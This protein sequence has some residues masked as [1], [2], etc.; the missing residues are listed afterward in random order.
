VTEIREEDL[1]IRILRAPHLG[2]CPVS[3]TVYTEIEH[4]PTGTVVR[5]GTEASQLQNKA[6]AIKALEVI[7][8]E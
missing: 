2:M 3:M 7:L 6:K 5:V 8:G 4:I 1:E